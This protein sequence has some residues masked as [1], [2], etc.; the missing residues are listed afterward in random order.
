MAPG[1]AT[2]RDPVAPTSR[3]AHRFHPAPGQPDCPSPWFRGLGA[4]AQE[5]WARLL[6]MPGQ[7]ARQLQASTGRGRRTVYDALERLAWHGLVTHEQGV[8]EA[9]QADRKR[10]DE[11]AQALG[12]AGRAEARKEQYADERENYVTRLLAEQIE[13]YDAAHAP[14]KR[15]TKHPAAVRAS[16]MQHAR[17]AKSEQGVAEK[18]QQSPPP[19][20]P[21]GQ[22]QSAAS[23]IV[24]DDERKQSSNPPRIASPADKDGTP[25]SGRSP[26]KKFVL[27][28]SANQ[29]TPGEL[30]V[31]KRPARQ[32]RR[33]QAGRVLQNLVFCCDD[34]RPAAYAG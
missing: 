33:P 1:P 30:P 15:K 10:L 24:L 12:T 31:P 4:S 5:V 6:G 25:A 26:T 20:A 14:G 27:H 8:Y 19:T 28:T 9:V 21:N 16:E 17:V 29:S 11:I 22:E 18:Q 23:G 3:P 13:C 34:C 7:T 32:W 2:V